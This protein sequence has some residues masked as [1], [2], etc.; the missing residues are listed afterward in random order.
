MQAVDLGI[1]GYIFH[2]HR[3]KFTVDLGEKIEVNGQS[4]PKVPE[5]VK[6]VVLKGR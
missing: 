6:G 2:R 4:E 1:R 3:G 5:S